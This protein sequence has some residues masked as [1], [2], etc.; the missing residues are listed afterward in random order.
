SGS[1]NEVPPSRPCCSLVQNQFETA[2]WDPSAS[3]LPRISRAGDWLTGRATQR[4][5][6]QHTQVG[7]TADEGT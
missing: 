5:Q 4:C 3:H 1:Y 2:A 6:T 7:H